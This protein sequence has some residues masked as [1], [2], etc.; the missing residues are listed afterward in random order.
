MGEER[1]SDDAAPPRLTLVPA[2]A[3]EE[4]QGSL[5]RAQLALDR[6]A[7]DKA[8]AVLHATARFVELDVAQRSRIAELEGRAAD[9]G[10]RIKDLLAERS[11]SMAELRCL[12]ASAEAADLV[13]TTVDTQA[14]VDTTT[15]A[16][17]NAKLAE[18]EAALRVAL[19]RVEVLETQVDADA[20]VKSFLSAQWDAAEEQRAVG[21]AALERVASER[22]VALAQNQRDARLRDM[23]ARRLSVSAAEKGLLLA[24]K[25]EWR[26]LLSAAM[27]GSDDPLASVYK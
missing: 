9:D 8:A 11:R 22:D 17:L 19:A 15:K 14:A 7:A 5:E 10:A 24:I 16:W 27:S 6:A 23:I 26:A 20:G 12:R 25:D 3:L 4:L 21:A 2:A 13:R 1:A 18:T